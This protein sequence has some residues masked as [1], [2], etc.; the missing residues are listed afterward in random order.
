MCIDMD[1]CID[2]CIEMRIDT[3]IDMCLSICVIDI[4]SSRCAL[5]C[6]I[7]CIRVFI[8]EPCLLTRSSSLSISCRSARVRIS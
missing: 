8:L 5:C 6:D 1:M 7:E 4:L 3:R 2:M